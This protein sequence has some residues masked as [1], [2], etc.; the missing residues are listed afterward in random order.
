MTALG[1]ACLWT[2]EVCLKIRDDACKPRRDA[3]KHA[4]RRRAH[5]AE[6]LRDPTRA[7]RVPKARRLP[8]GLG[9]GGDFVMQIT[10]LCRGFLDHLLHI[11]AQIVI[12]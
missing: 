6:G 5:R 7:S 3:L 4:A 11:R 2:L 12:G 8:A 9:I 10:G 1:S